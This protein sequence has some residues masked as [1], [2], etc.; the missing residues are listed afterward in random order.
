MS[1]LFIC[2]V[3]LPPSLPPSPSDPSGVL[4]LL[5]SALSMDKLTSL[6]TEEHRNDSELL[7]QL[8]NRLEGKGSRAC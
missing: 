6:L 5:Q 7:L 4:N 1:E 8:Q 2:D 3:I